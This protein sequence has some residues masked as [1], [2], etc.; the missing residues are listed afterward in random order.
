MYEEAEDNGRLVLIK[1]FADYPESKQYFKTIPTE[2]GLHNNSVVAF[3]GSRVMAAMNQVFENI[4]NWHQV[5]KLLECLVD[6]HKNIHKVPLGMF[7]AMFRV[8][9]SVCQDLL[10][11]DFTDN[12]LVSWEKLVGALCEEL[13]AAYARNHRIS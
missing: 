8:M 4:D 9:R 3:H 10:E 5:C 7:Q 6:T 12:M 13:A 2:G 1:F 11:N